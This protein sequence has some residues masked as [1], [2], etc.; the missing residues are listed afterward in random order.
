[1]RVKNDANMNKHKAIKPSSPFLSKIAKLIFKPAIKRHKDNS[2]DPKNSN[3]ISFCVV[4]LTLYGAGLVCYAINFFF[5]AFRLC[6][7][8]KLKITD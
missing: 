8:K 2:K 1:M 7:V 6:C 5:K 4:N 3:K